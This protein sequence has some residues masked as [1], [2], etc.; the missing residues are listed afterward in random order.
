[1]LFEEEIK[2]SS[3]LIINSHYTISLTGAGI[4][5]PSGI[6]DFRSPSSGIWA[7][8]DPME[9]ATI[10]A[11]KQNP[12]KFFEFMNSLNLSIFSAEPNPAH[13]ALAK[14]E[15]KG[16]LQL[17]VTQNIDSLHQ[18]AGSKKVIE[19]HG[20]LRGVICLRCRKIS[21]MEDFI[22][23][24][25]ENKD[26]KNYYPTCSECGGILKPDVVL[27]GE[28][29]PTDALYTAHRAAQECEVMIVVGSSL[30]VQPIASLPEIA[31]GSGAKIIV[32][33]LQP[34]YIDK[35]ARVVIRGEVDKVLPQIVKH[36]E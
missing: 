25:Q 23:L 4:S 34:T 9:V 11:F 10:W 32:I 21:P 14:L 27:F 26:D 19:V 17:L 5:T 8:V 16:L 31:Y 15:E 22:K 29:L 1:M 20:N 13:Y 24:F 2:L 6:P 7:K 30:V 12:R 18:K 28:A 3:E 36:I 33:N 35:R